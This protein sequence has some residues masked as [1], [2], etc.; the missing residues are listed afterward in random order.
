MTSSDERAAAAI[1][2]LF[3]EEDDAGRTDR[4]WWPICESREK[5]VSQTVNQY[6]YR[7]ESKINHERSWGFTW[8]SISY[9]FKI[10]T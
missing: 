5:I 3:D 7:K 2:L 9:D 4:R 6:A 1:Y 10:T 8:V